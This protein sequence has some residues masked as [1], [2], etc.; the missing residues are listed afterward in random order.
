MSEKAEKTWELGLFKIKKLLPPPPLPPIPVFDYVIDIYSD[1]IVITNPDGSTT[2]L[3]TISDLNNWLGNV[4]G[5]KIRINVN[6][7][8][9]RDIYLTPNEYWIFGERVSGTIYLLSGKHTI[10][11]FA[12]LGEVTNYTWRPTVYYDI[13]GSRL[14]ILYAEYVDITGTSDMMLDDLVIVVYHSYST[15]LEYAVNSDLYAQ[16]Y[17]IHSAVSVLRNVYINAGYAN[18]EDV[19][20]SGNVGSWLVV[21]HREAGASPLDLT[22][23]RVAVLHLIDTW[24]IG[25]SPRSTFKIWLPNIKGTNWT[26]FKVIAIGVERCGEYVCVVDPLPP[27]VTYTVDVDSG[28]LRIE[29]NTDSSYD[30]AVVYEVH[31]FRYRY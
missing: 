26:F 17:F 23:V 3:T 6:V 29:N 4:T 18:F 12:Q 31:A 25:V 9:S 19:R 11:S 7:E 15:S 20:T 2:Q 8:V 27:D 5:R 16:G 21:S 13:S 28:E 22:N 14:F 24:R 10:V 1:K 30:I